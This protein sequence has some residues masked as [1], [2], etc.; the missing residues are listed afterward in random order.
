VPKS[1][2][3]NGVAHDIAHHG[4]SGLSWLYPHLG[5]ACREAGVL[6]ATVDLLD[7]QPYPLGLPNRTPLGLALSSMRQTLAAI[8]EQHGFRLA[9]VTSARLEFT[10]PSGYGDGSLYSVR[11]TLVYRGR[12]YERFLPLM[13]VR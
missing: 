7:E 1:A 8:L 2:V 5:E 6:T 12:T 13:Q 3:M 9:D 4:Q 11:S 10:F